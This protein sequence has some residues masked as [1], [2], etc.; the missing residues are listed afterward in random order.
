MTILLDSHE[1]RGGSA[2]ASKS[3]SGTS[4]P[5]EGAKQK[6]VAR[7][8][9]LAGKQRKKEEYERRRAENAAKKVQGSES[10]D[11]PPEGGQS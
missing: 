4:T 9:F 7:Q 1:T 2:S 8:E 6:E 5:N 3:A 11:R 10:S